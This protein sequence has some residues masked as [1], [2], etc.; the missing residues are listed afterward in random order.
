MISGNTPDEM[1]TRPRR[2]RLDEYMRNLFR[3]VESPA[4]KMQSAVDLAE[5]FDSLDS[6]VLVM[7]REGIIKALNQAACALAKGASK[8][9]LGR[10]VGKLGDGQVWA[11]LAEQVELVQHLSYPL[12][13]EIADESSAIIWEFTASL[14]A[15]NLTGQHIILRGRDVTGRRADGADSPPTGGIPGRH[16]GDN[17]RHHVQA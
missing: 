4:P 2:P 17:S 11:K 15:D 3:K 6:P 1:L 5:V 13:C 10:P 9:I 16:T 8:E 14:T 7:D 12:V